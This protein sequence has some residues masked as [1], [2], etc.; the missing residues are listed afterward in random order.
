[1]KTSPSFS[2]CLPFAP[3]C[4]LSW[5]FLRWKI[6]PEMVETLQRDHIEK[7][8]FEI[9]FNLSLYQV[10]G[11]GT[12]PTQSIFSTFFSSPLWRHCSKI[13]V[14]AFAKF[15]RFYSAFSQ[16]EKEV[17]VRCIYNRRRRTIIGCV[18]LSFWHFGESE[19]DTTMTALQE[20]I[21]LS[22]LIELNAS[23]KFSAQLLM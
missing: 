19:H 8:Q 4:L 17:D 14:L 7:M 9:V 16:L 11:F 6:N 3:V 2:I 15:S 18:Y 13:F 20:I 10:G 12:S 21:R 1:M 5:E 23:F 22:V